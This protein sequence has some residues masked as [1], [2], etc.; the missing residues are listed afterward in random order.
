MA[1]YGS[2][3]GR[4]IPL[5]VFAVIALVIIGV[6]QLSHILPGTRRSRDA[7]ETLKPEQVAWVAF[8]PGSYKPAL[9][10]PVTVRDS[11]TIVEIVRA[12]TNL[13][14]HSNQHPSTIKSAF[15]RI[16]LKSGADVGGQLITTNND[17][18]IFTVFSDIT[19]GWVLANYEVPMGPAIFDRIA[20][21][22]AQP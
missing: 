16:H 15:V 17:G 14:G 5:W 7:Y 10:A 13:P 9:T 19:Q 4:R 6:P 3:G 12:F 8:E 11:A 20:K 1:V 18:T 2:S 22:T 21:W